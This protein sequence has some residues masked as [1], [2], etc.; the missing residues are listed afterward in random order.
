MDMEAFMYLQAM[1]YASPKAIWNLFLGA[2]GPPFGPKE[3]LISTSRLFLNYFAL[4]YMIN[5]VHLSSTS[6][7]FAIYFSLLCILMHK[8]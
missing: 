6:C 1:Q 7:F 8:H 2:S 5:F 4:L 3:G